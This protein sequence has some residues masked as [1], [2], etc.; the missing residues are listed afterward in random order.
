MRRSLARLRRALVGDPVVLP[1]AL[2]ARF[3][4]LREARWRRGGVP[5]R[6]GGWCL[7]RATVGGIAVGRTVFL[8]P[9]AALRPAFLLHEVAHVRQFAAERWFVVRYWWQSL[10]VGYRRN[11]YERA[12]DAFAAARL[13]PIAPVSTPVAAEA[14]SVDLRPAD[15]L[16]ARGT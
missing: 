15:A 7:G 8:A 4:E 1:A 10:R 16:R 3:P 11:P 9:G 13:A 2:L 6:V 5:P 14:A 12:A